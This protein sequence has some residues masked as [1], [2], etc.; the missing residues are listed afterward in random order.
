MAFMTLAMAQLFHLGNARSRASVLSPGRAFA[1]GFAVAAV[2]LGILLQVVAVYLP[3]LRNL[4]ELV[5]LSPREW[6]IVTA[7]SAATGLIGQATKYRAATSRVAANP[8]EGRTT[9]R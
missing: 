5:P 3:A 7:L 2:A 9:L 8:D 6:V 4:L 1:N